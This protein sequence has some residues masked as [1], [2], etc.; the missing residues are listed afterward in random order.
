MSVAQL[1]DF[2]RKVVGG[3]SGPKQVE[4]ME[5]EKSSLDSVN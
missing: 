4:T 1:V 3:F 2:K 5:R